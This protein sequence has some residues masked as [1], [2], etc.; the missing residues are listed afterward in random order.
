VFDG[1]G[2]DE[3]ALHCREHL[4]N[5]VL[6]SPEF[7]NRDLSGAL[8]HGLDCAEREILSQQLTQCGNACGM[9]SGTTA[10]AALICE[11]AMS[12]A[13]VGDCR[14]VLCR[15]GDAVTLTEDHRLSAAS[16][17]SRILRDGGT[18]EG[19]RL[20]GCLAV[21]RALGGVELEAQ[22]KFP[23]LSATPEVISQIVDPSDEFLVLGSDGLWD[24][25]SPQ[26]AI[27][28]ARAELQAYDDAGMASERLI[29]VALKR[30][31][32]DNVTALVVR[33]NAPPQEPP[34]RRPRLNLTP[35]S[36]QKSDASGTSGGTPP[37]PFPHVQVPTA[38]L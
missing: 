1:H 11:R 29:E 8:L 5:H 23:G 24:V 12:V 19:G 32:D 18:V 14:A 27:G 28:F 36:G 2:G 38:P 25:M 4:H 37:C 6:S 35:Q 33:M 3:A 31:T 7:R 13:W 16:E 34:R 22:R 10:V 26:E 21:A 9:C 30:K 17:V 20:G 15:N